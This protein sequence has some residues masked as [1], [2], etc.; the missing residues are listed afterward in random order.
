MT[1]SKQKF[2]TILT[3]LTNRQTETVWRELIGYACDRGIAHGDYDA[4]AA[5]FQAAKKNAVHPTLYNAAVE[6]GILGK[7][8]IFV[9]Q[10]RDTPEKRF[11]VEL[12]LRVRRK[13][14]KTR[15]EADTAL[16][17]FVHKFTDLWTQV[18]LEKAAEKAAEKAERQKDAAYQTKRINDALKR[19]AKLL[20]DIKSLGFEVVELDDGTYTVE[21]RAAQEEEAA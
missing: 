1:I 9:S 12:T 10:K 2:E 7:N 14:D 16:K 8:G 18:Q 20:K 5:V 11:G 15:T 19:F 3:T 4:L 13:K 6:A 17:L 21:P